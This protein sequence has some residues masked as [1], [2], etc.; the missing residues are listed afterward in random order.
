[1]NKLLA[2]TTEYPWEGIGG[3]S[4]RQDDPIGAL[5]KALSGV[6]GFLTLVG[7]IYFVIQIILAGYGWIS[8]GGDS[9]QLENAQKKIWQSVLGLVIIILAMVFVSLV[10]YL[11]GG[12][13][14]LNFSGNLRN[15]F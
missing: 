14:F 6:I 9:G 1:M 12:I 2:A 13:D 4:Q 11:L 8:A 3:L 5:A 15:L 10:G 7:A